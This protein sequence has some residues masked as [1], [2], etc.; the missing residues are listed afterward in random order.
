M[1][2]RPQPFNDLDPFNDFDPE[3]CSYLPPSPAPNQSGN[4]QPHFFNNH[5]HHQHNINHAMDQYQPQGGDQWQPPPQ[6]GGPQGVP[7]GGPMNPGPGDLPQ[8][9]NTFMWQQN[10][11]M[12][13]NPE[14]GFISGNNTNPASMTGHEAGDESLLD[15]NFQGMSGPS[16]VAGSLYNLDSMPHSGKNPEIAYKGANLSSTRASRF[17]E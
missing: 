4:N 9:D 5:N 10:N 14:S 7:P 8:M 3:I 6:A 2:R 1:N 12:P 16:S 17:N 11:Y 15:A 13:E